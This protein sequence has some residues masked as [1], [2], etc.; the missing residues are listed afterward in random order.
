ME[1]GFINWSI[2]Y[3]PSIVYGLT[4]QGHK[5]HYDLTKQLQEENDKE[6]KDQKNA[7]TQNGLWWMTLWILIPTWVLLLLTLAMLLQSR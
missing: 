1:Y 2:G 6:S 7:K 5:L 4:Y 3:H